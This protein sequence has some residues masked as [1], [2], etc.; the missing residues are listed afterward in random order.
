MNEAAYHGVDFSGG[1]RH[2]RKVRIASL[3]PGVNITVR[4]GV[5]RAGL[6]EAIA[7][8][9][10]DGRRHFWLLDA[11]FGLPVELLEIHGIEPRWTAAARWLASFS[12]AREWRSACRERSRK[13]LRR[14]TDRIAHT[15]LSPA[16][17]RMF[18]QTWHCIVSVLLPLSDRPGFAI[19]PLEIGPGGAG[20][21]EARVWV[22]EGCPSSSLRRANWPNR[23]YKGPTE[24]NRAVRRDLVQRLQREE[25]IQVPP[26]V[27]AEALEDPEGDVLDALLLL[28]AARR[29]EQNDPAE[30]AAKEPRASVEGWVFE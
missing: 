20:A 25:G 24:A 2:D 22:G 23:G 30:I 26:E 13:E 6:V 21:A 19:P 10:E 16:N 5:S 3:V 1:R 28:P 8:S 7:R 4:G 15:P 27:E 11:A 29:F 17:L 12:D 18:R 9:A 14:L